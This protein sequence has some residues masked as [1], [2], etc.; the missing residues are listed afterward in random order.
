M[1]I[2]SELKDAQLEVVDGEKT[3]SANTPA[4][5]WFDRLANK[6]KAMYNGVIEILA[7]E[8]WVTEQI[9]NSETS[10]KENGLITDDL[11]A[12]PATPAADTKHLYAKADGLY[13]REESGD[14]HKLAKTSAESVLDLYTIEVNIRQLNYDSGSYSITAF[15]VPTGY[16]WSFVGTAQCFAALGPTYYPRNVDFDGKRFYNDGGSSS[17][18]SGVTHGF[19]VVGSGTNTGNISVV[20]S[21]EGD[22]TSLRKLQGIVTLYRKQ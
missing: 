15:N 6:V 12:D 11:V 4:M 17:D 18:T 3:F 20:F 8:S 1:D 9:G 13:Y 2:N 16:T 14:V 7:T 22:H 21:G 10:L 19:G 5:I